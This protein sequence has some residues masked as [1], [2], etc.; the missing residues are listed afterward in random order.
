MKDTDQNLLMISSKKSRPWTA[1][2]DYIKTSIVFIISLEKIEL[3]IKIK[4][5]WL[6]NDSNLIY[7]TK[8]TMP[9]IDINLY[10]H[11]QKNILLRT[12]RVGG[13]NSI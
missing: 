7:L 13:E 10:K 1:L 9:C 2:V 4:H 6:I 8:A 12:G 3:I 11:T 5:N